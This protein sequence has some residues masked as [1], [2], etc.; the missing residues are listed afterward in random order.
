MVVI[1]YFAFIIYLS[2]YFQFILS[3]N[4][5][6]SDG[7][8]SSRG[9]SYNNNNAS[10]R[11]GGRQNAAPSHHNNS[12]GHLERLSRGGHSRG[13]TQSAPSAHHS[14][15]HDSPTAQPSNRKGARGS[16]AQNQ[17]QSQS[18]QSQG[19]SQAHQESSQRRCSD[20]SDYSSLVEAMDRDLDRPESP[21]NAE[22]F[23]E[24]AAAT[25]A[26]AQATQSKGTGHALTSGWGGGFCYLLFF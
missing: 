21:A 8:H 22:V 26:A 19:Q 24:P 18:Q 1:F 11:P 4:D 17:N 3:S 7:N 2:Q 23:Q 6:N 9:G 12:N 10:S 16:R 13:A 14:K 5:N 25:A 20:D 15:S